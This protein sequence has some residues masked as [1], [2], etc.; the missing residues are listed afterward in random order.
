MTYLPFAFCDVKILFKLPNWNVSGTLTRIDLALMRIENGSQPFI[1]EKRRQRRRHLRK[2][3][4]AKDDCLENHFFSLFVKMQ[5]III[6]RY[7]DQIISRVQTWPQFN[8][9]MHFS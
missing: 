9:E 1:F 8:Q 4:L 2:L 6:Y 7:G 5:K 3:E